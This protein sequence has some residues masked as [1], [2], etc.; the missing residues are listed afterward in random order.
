MISKALVIGCGISGS[1]IA[2]ELAETGA[3]VT[4]LE[5][6]KH[7]GGN[8]YDYTDEHGFLVSKYGPHAFHTNDSDIYEYIKHF[9]DWKPYRLEC[10]A[11]WNDT[12]TCVPFNYTCIDKFFNKEEAERLKKEFNRIFTDK[13]EITVIEALKHEN[14][15]VRMFAEFLFKNDYAPYT[16]KQWNIK[17]EDIDASVLK[18]VPIRF[19]Y[20]EGYFSDIY[21]VYPEHSYTDFIRNILNHKNINVKTDIDGLADLEIKG[22]NIYYENELCFYPVIFTGPIDELFDCNYGKLPYRS[23]RFEWKYI[24]KDSLQEAAIVAY[25]KAEKYTRITEYKKIP[26]QDGHGT[27]CAIE[28]PIPYE[29]ESGAEPYYPILTDQSQEL[30]GKYKT[31]AVEIDNLYCCGRL[32]EFKYYNMDQAIKSALRTSKQ[33]IEDY[34]DNDSLLIVM[35]AYNE[36]ANIENIINAWLP[37]VNNKKEGSGIII[38][39]SGSKDRTLSIIK[40]LQADNPV[41]SVITDSINTYGNKVID[42]YDYAISLKP[43]YVFLTDSDGQTDPQDFPDFWKKRKKYDAIIGFRKERGDGKSRLFVEK[44][45]CFL[46]AMICGVQIPDANTPFRLMKLDYLKDALQTIPRDYSMPNIMLSIHGAMAQNDICY[47]EI[48]FGCR[49]G[50]QNKMNY[51]KIISIGMESLVKFREYAKKMKRSRNR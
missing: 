12:Y 49:Q 32:G 24:E 11:C 7:I 33:I 38:N 41:I 29:K 31:R 51:K 3:Q 25:P 44:V 26:D 10:G 14:P 5:K 9:E 34:T 23:L 37:A 42:L 8:I 2:R 21:Q 22:N 39:C 48:S 28:Y 4:V 43:D 16:A 6:R 27:V 19:S 20:E 45:V 46:I 13:K 1:I 30:Y 17:P 50:G 35:P 15:D 40:K 47:K 36:E 18:R